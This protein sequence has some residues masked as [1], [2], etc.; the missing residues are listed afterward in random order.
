MWER[1]GLVHSV[2]W[3]T[4][5]WIFADRNLMLIFQPCFTLPT[6]DEMIPD[7]K[8][9]LYLSPLSLD[10]QIVC[11]NNSLLFISLKDWICERKNEHSFKRQKSKR[12]NTVRAAKTY[13]PFK[14][15]KHNLKLKKYSK[16]WQGPNL[17]DVSDEYFPLRVYPTLRC[18]TAQREFKTESQVFAEEKKKKWKKKSDRFISVVFQGDGF[19]CPKKEISSGGW[20]L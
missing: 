2:F 17:T 8:L 4:L 16:L 15:T 12:A 1:E 9:T 14:Q 11:Q 19:L 5:K 6:S 3:E 18:K 13:I 10:S 20:K 7:Q